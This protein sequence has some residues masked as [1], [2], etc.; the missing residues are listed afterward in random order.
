VSKCAGFF[1]LTTG[2]NVG[3]YDPALAGYDLS[4]SFTDSA[5]FVNGFTGVTG[6]ESTSLGDLIITGGD[7][8]HPSTTFTATVTG[9]SSVPEPSGI[10]LLG[11]GLLG[12]V[13]ALR[14][15]LF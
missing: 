1:D 3:I 14:R 10:V 7:S 4:S 2:S 11:T 13:G 8:Q 5:Y 15:R 12:A 9:V 6:P